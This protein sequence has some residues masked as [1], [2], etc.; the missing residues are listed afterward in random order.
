MNKIEVKKLFWKLVDEIEYCSDAVVENEVGVV[1]ERGM[2]LSNDYSI[3]F[4][5]DDGVVRIYNKEH[6]PLIAFTEESEVLL[7]MKELFESLEV[8]KDEA[9][10]TK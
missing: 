3:M 2:L 10:C 9:A 4:G 8:F 1:V 6:F 5:L 7:I